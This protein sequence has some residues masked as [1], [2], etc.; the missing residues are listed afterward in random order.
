MKTLSLIISSFILF[1]GCGAASNSI[2]TPAG[3]SNTSKALTAFSF[4][5]PAATGTVT[6]SNHTIAITVPYGTDETGLIATF[7][8]TG[9]SV[10]V[11][12]TTQVSGTTANNFTRCFQSFF[13]GLNR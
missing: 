8:T 11:G 4:A 2:S 1:S 12:S 6:E 5:S 9:A 13:E 3:S 10:K 7:T